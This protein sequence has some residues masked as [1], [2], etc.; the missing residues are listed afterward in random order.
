MDNFVKT[1]DAESFAAV[2]A[3]HTHVI[4]AESITQIEDN[5]ERSRAVSELQQRARALASEI[6]HRKEIEKALRESLVREQ[7]LREQA[8][9]NV[10][11]ADIFAGMLGHDLRNPLGT[12]TMGA[13]YIARAKPNDRLTRAATRISSR[14]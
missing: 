8:E 14:P 12:I 4:P 2:C 7:R 10:H 6:E 11:F 1:S 9:R 13:S 3:S 5:T